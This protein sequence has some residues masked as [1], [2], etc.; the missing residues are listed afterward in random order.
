MRLPDLQ[1]RL[2]VVPTSDS[3]SLQSNCCSEL[4]GDYRSILRLE[5]RYLDNVIAKALGRQA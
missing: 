4:G 3:V 5:I 2:I 1:S